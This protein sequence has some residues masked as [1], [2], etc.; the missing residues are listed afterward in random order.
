MDTCQGDSGGPLVCLEE[1]SSAI[2]LHGVTSFGIGCAQPRFPGV[3][4]RV[5][6]YVEW[7]NETTQIV[8][9]MLCQYQY[10]LS[11]YCPLFR[12]G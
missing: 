12:E 6:S 3:Y 4:A 7:I 8:L 9:S 5:T 2:V 10:S 1:S 11:L